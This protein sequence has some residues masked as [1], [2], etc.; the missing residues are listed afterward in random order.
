[1]KI[2]TTVSLVVMALLG[3]CGQGPQQT[4]TAEESA[5]TALDKALAALGGA[6]DQRNDS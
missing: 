5:P 1:M 6:E 3:A 4:D 2:N